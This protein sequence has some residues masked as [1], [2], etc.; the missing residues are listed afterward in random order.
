[1]NRKALKYTFTILSVLFILNLAVTGFL[2]FSVSGLDNRVD[3]LE[4]ESNLVTDYLLQAGEYS[5]AHQDVEMVERET[6]AFVAYDSA[7]ESGVIFDYNFQPLPTETI[8]VDAS[9][10]RV[11][12]S[13]QNSLRN[14]Q[15]A[16]QQSDYEPAA[17]GM[18][19][20]LD[21]PSDWEYVRGESAGLAV[22]A[23]FASTDPNYV[24]ND[25]VA[26]TGQVQDNGNVVSVNHISSKG[27]AAGEEGKEVLVA[28]HTNSAVSAEGVEIVHVQSLD[29]ALE[30]ALD[31]I[32]E[33]EDRSESE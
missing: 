4:E 11:E 30:Y 27:E 32:D 15:S 16:V 19:I 31:P 25:S 33:D 7:E 24:M 22:A 8:Y 18:A 29:E 20:S 12:D 6:G 10:V 23:Q 5:E 17:R 14:A 21:T 3:T 26:L 28:P 2:L 13:F 9:Q 1:M